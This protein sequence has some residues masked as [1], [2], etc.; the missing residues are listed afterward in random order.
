MCFCVCVCV[1]VRVRACACVRECV[2]TCVCVC[3]HA[4]VCACVLL[5]LFVVV[6]TVERCCDPMC[7]MVHIPLVF[8]TLSLARVLVCSADLQAISLLIYLQEWQTL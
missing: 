7:P 1:C 2:R 8:P 3:V 6:C 4:R 5:C